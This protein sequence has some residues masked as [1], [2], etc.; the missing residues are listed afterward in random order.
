MIA[1]NKSQVAKALTDG[2]ITRDDL[3]DILN[4]WQPKKRGPKENLMRQ[5]SVLA[6]FA[7]LTDKH[8]TKR[9]TKTLA[10]EI[11]AAK[12]EYYG[13]NAMG[14]LIDRAKRNWFAL[15]PYDDVI[16]SKGCRIRSITLVC[17]NPAHYGVHMGFTIKIADWRF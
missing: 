12:G 15:P 6:V 3:Q 5:A 16:D 10:L 14:R 2:L 7:Q 9:M 11:I 8:V 17:K 4:G 13:I 1:V